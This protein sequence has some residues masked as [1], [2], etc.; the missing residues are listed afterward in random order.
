MQKLQNQILG[1]FLVSMLAACSS[2]PS[3]K[4]VAKDQAAAEQI[5]DRAAQ[6]RMDQRNSALKEQLNQVP[7]WARMTPAPDVE[8]VYA[9]GIGQSDDYAVAINKADL[10]AEFGLAKS[11][12]QLLSGSERIYTKDDAD[13]ANRDQYVRLIDNLVPQIP[14]SGYKRIDQTVAVSNGKYVAYVLMKMPYDQLNKTI[15]QD[16]QSS[17]DQEIKQ[18]FGDLSDRL[19]KLRERNANNATAPISDAPSA[20]LH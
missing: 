2:Q 17:G 18:A 8:G 20:S 5:S 3:L 11:L 10:S 13:G 9:I 16:Q 4:D 6:D 19:D 7:T 12:K 1:L 14:L 15:L